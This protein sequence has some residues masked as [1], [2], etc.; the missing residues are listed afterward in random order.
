MENTSGQDYMSNFLKL[1][2]I[3]GVLLVAFVFTFNYL[4][5]EEYPLILD[6]DSLNYF[7]DKVETDR[8]ISFVV[9]QNN[10]KF[11][12]PWAKNFNYEESPSLS[13]V[14]SNGDF[15]SKKPFSDTVWVKHSGKQYL[16][17]LSEAIEKQP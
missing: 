6:K 3:G 12:I 11:T 2:G 9:F 7:V 16:F 17:V 4:R 5:S 1:M 8:S 13:E 15:V 14:L 10:K